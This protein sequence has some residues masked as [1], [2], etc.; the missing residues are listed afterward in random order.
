M[1]TIDFFRGR[2]I[3]H[4]RTYA[5]ADEGYDG[6]VHDPSNIDEIVAKQQA[7]LAKSYE[8]GDPHPHG[9]ALPDRPADLS[10]DGVTSRRPEF[11]STSLI[12]GARPGVDVSSLE[13]RF[14]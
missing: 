3:G 4:Q 13:D 6:K 5:L 10:R 14:R 11:E 7:A 12:D 2:D 9:R 1:L 8:W